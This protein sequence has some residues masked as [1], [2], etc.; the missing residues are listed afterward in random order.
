VV[1]R[2]DRGL[3][4]LLELPQEEAAGGSSGGDPSAAPP[5][6]GWAHLSNLVDGEPLPAD[7][8]ES[9]YKVGGGGGRG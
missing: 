7:Q 9:R 3:G 2:V 5:A 4:L 8:L 1:R 6:A